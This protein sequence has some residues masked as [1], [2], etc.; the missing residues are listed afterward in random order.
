MIQKGTYLIPVDKCGVWWVGVFHIYGGFKKRI[1]RNGNFVKVSVKSTRPD[2]WVSKK[3]KLN[4]IVTLT[5]KEVK[6]IDGSYFK[7][8]NN[9][10]VLLKKRLS[11]KG[12]EIMGP[13]LKIIKRKKFMMSF[14]GT[15]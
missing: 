3:S 11:A 5:K 7:F 8:K 13:C 4:G 1:G 14:S 6:L 9:N 12:K 10:V 2:N 15:L